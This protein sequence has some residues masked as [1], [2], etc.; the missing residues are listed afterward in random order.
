MDGICV[1]V[2]AMNAERTV[3]RAVA[4]AL[5]E[6]D[7]R[8]VV[9]IDD[10]SRDA[11]VA[12][13]RSADDGSGRLAIHRNRSNLGPAASRNLGITRSS[14]PLVAV[15]DADDVILPGR[16]A[17]MADPQGNWDVSADN[18]MFVAE[19]EACAMTGLAAFD[20]G[21]VA[22][23]MSFAHFVEANI[24]R[25]GR[26]RGELGFL[27]PVMRRSFL[28]RHGLAYDL[29]L[30]LGEDF[31]LYARML[32]AGARFRLVATCG[33]LAIEPPDHLCAHYS[34][35]D[36]AAL[37]AAD[38]RMLMRPLRPA[39][40]TILALHRAQLAK[41]WH[42][43]QFLDAKRSSGLMRALM[44]HRD[45]PRLLLDAGLGVARDK[46]APLWTRGA[47]PPRHRFLITP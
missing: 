24:S 46:L 17:A 35:G 3:A 25:P 1:I 4:S 33:Y 21:G 31:D 11:T 14:A 7:V 37:V 41:R 6:R 30:R 45:R 36:L 9:V 19:D 42:H 38:D 44:A 2:A 40:R 28:Q 47:P 26:P 22:E 32:L 10:A 23:Q 20:T 15:L 12:A 27:K 8:E 16:F 13:A 5:A 29:R 39:D 43:L 18:I 34:A